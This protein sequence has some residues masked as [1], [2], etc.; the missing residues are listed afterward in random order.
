MQNNISKVQEDWS[1]RAKTIQ[2]FLLAQSHLYH[3]TIL[4]NCNIVRI[5]VPR[6]YLKFMNHGI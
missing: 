5:I 3:G 6:L 2:I 1:W 4:R